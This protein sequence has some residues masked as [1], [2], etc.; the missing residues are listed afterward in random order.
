MHAVLK[1]MLCSKTFGFCELALRSQMS[2][3]WKFRETYEE[4]NRCLL[5]AMKV[6]SMSVL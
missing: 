5:L 1:L 4:L 3:C 6:T 2:D